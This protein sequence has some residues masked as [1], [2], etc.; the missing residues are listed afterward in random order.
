[1]SIHYAL[2]HLSDI[3]ILYLPYKNRHRGLCQVKQ[4]VKEEICA[5][6]DYI[7]DSHKQALIQVKKIATY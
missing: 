3:A 2:H 1:M 7:K 5:L 6:S 4:T